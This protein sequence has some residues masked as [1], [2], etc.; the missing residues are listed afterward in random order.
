MDFDQVL[1]DPPHPNS[2]LP[3]YD[4][5]DGIHANIAGQLVSRASS[6]FP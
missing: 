5:G 3:V 1:K 4:I 2:I 6:S